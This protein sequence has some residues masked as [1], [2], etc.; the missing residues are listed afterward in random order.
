MTNLKLQP[1]EVILLQT[2]GGCRYNGE[3]ETEIDELYLT[4]KNIIFVCEESK[5]FFSSKTE[6]HLSKIPLT[7]P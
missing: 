2:S 4:N 1:G 6:T 7:Q 3:N 5:G